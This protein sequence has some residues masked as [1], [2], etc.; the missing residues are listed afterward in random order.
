[1]HH[2]QD[3][4][5]KLHLHLAYGIFWG[6][7]LSTFL[8]IFLCDLFY[9]ISSSH[10]FQTMIMGSILSSIPGTLLLFSSTRYLKLSN[11]GTLNLILC[12]LIFAIQIAAN[13]IL[14]IVTWLFFLL[15]ILDR[16]L[17][18]HLPEFNNAVFQFV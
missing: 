6:G 14:V 13:F 2:P 15:C 18:L 12:F 9:T 11:N 7:A 16:T 10:A 4:C 3:T 8:L 5:F 17:C 1:M